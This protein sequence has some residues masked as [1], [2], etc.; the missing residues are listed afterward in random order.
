MVSL[1]RKGMMR[2]SDSPFAS[3]RWRFATGVSEAV[4]GWAIT[5]LSRKVYFDAIAGKNTRQFRCLR[6]ALLASR[7][8]SEA[9][10]DLCNQRPRS[11]DHG[12]KRQ[13][14]HHG[15]CSPAPRLRIPIFSPAGELFYSNNGGPWRGRI[16]SERERESDLAPSATPACLA[17]CL[18]GLK[19]VTARHLRPS[20]GG[21]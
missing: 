15:L 21:S 14:C 5:S 19:P 4:F 6:R 10:R 7:L 8:Q 12:Q 2:C 13:R 17:S 18:L 20:R 1:F 16:E 3:R 11:A 9:T